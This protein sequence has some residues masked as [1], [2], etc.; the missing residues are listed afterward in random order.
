[1]P[2]DIDAMLSEMQ[3]ILESLPESNAP[4]NDP[5]L[6]REEWQTH[7]RIPKSTARERMV[8]LSR[9][10]A[11]EVGHRIILGIDGRRCRVPVYRPKT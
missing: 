4:E 9:A 10:G 11:L 3:S 6:T 5:G 1:M 2:P 8:Q 7:W